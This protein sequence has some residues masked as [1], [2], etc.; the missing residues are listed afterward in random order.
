MGVYIKGIDMPTK[1]TT[2]TIF[3]NGYVAIYDAQDSFIGETKA[4]PVPPHGRLGDL[5]RLEAQWAN[6]DHGAY[7]DKTNFV[8][9]IQK[10][11]TIIPASDKDINVPSKE[12]EA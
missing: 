6:C 11:P 4:I 12:G 2:F 1:Q 7:Y 3:P 10:A 8:R 9:S 5:D